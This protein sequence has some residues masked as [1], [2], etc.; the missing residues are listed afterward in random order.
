MTAANSIFKQR[1]Y[2]LP[3]FDSPFDVSPAEG[4]PAIGKF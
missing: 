3:L 2:D 1:N 4:V